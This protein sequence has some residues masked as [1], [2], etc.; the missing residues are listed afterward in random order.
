MVLKRKLPTQNETEAADK[1]K[2]ADPQ[3]KKVNTAEAQAEE[4]HASRYA[5]AHAEEQA[6][7]TASQPTEPVTPG[8]PTQKEAAQRSEKPTE[9]QVEKTPEKKAEA[10]APLKRRKPEGASTTSQSQDKPVPQKQKDT[11]PAAKAPKAEKES[12]K[13]PKHGTAQADKPAM[14]KVDA[15]K[16][17]P[18]SDFKIPDIAPLGMPLEPEMPAEAKSETTPSGSTMP[19]MDQPAAH[20]K[21]PDDA[22]KVDAPTPLGAPSPLGGGDDKAPA[23][24]SNWLSDDAP[25]PLGGDTP[26]GDAFAKPSDPFAVEPITPPSMTPPS[27]GEEAPK[28]G[29]AFGSYMQ[30]EG[31][32]EMPSEE[33]KP[34]FSF[35]SA[36]QPP[37]KR[38]KASSSK[39]DNPPVLPDAFQAAKDS[40][41]T[42]FI[43]KVVTGVIALAVVLFAVKMFNERDKATEMLARWTG[44]LKQVSEDVPE[45]H[46][47]NPALVEPE[48]IVQLGQD[49]QDDRPASTVVE[50]EIY[51]ELPDLEGLG[52]N[53]QIEMLDV[54]DAEAKEPIVASE[55]DEMPEDLSLFANIQRAIN[56]AQAEKKVE[57]AQ[58]KGLNV[59]DESELSDEEIYLRNREMTLE[60]QQQLTD[61]RKALAQESDPLKKPKP[62]EFFAGEAGGKQQTSNK[63]EA[64]MTEGARFGANPYDLPVVPE[65]SNEAEA[66]TV[67]TLADFEAV[68]Y[69]KQESRIRMPRGV[70]PQLKNSDMVALEILSF[71]P[72]R[73][74]IAFHQGREGVLLIGESIEGW[75]LVAVYEHYAEFSNGTR[76][77]TVT[78]K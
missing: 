62:S 77:Q 33:K 21:A 1:N 66:P 73:G 4:A 14:P 37:W 50:T 67:R 44:T 12:A 31:M 15:Q 61:Y 24:T 58:E 32:E 63:E 48:D 9:K 29:A 47:E 45:T 19:W 20:N 53:T 76:R 54:S 71:V 60:L 43:G 64:E 70:R 23:S 39:A 3:E 51:D 16:T 8:A 6:A 40:G 52:G 35:A 10:P 36:G 57:E 25:A 78:M 75:E 72:N 49:E 27:L 13:E 11:Q 56:E 2:P 38:D 65:P 46:D 68:M 28:Q 26:T 30:E 41:K 7:E 5:A 22:P 69:D 34:A 74:I 55:D 59:K 42:G 18:P 17:P